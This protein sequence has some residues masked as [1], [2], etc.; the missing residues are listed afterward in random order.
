MQQ[1]IMDCSGIADGLQLHEAFAQAL[2]FPGWYGKNLDA[3]YD[4]LTAIC[5]DTAICLRDFENLGAWKNGFRCVLE[6]ACE[7][8]PLL[9]IT[10]EN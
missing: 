2:G 10:W 5:Q 1:V 7:A 3:L 9:H 8:N 6:D 4:C